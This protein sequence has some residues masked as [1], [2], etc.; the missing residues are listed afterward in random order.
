MWLEAR[1]HAGEG[2]SGRVVQQALC[3]H[4]ARWMH[5]FF[6][7]TSHLPPHFPAPSVPLATSLRCNIGAMGLF[8]H[9]GKADVVMKAQ[10]LAGGRGLGTFTNGFQGGV[11]IVTR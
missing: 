1:R 8:V 11:H 6:P 5:V 4:A 7:P 2:G 9:A 10:V 3:A